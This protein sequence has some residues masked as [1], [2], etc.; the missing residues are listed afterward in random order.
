MPGWVWGRWF[1]SW[2]VPFCLCPFGPPTRTE[3]PLFGP[4]TPVVWLWLGLAHL[5]L[6]LFL[7]S[8]GLLLL[9]AWAAPCPFTYSLL[10]GGNFSSGSRGD[11]QPPWALEV[12]D[13]APMGP[14][15]VVPGGCRSWGHCL[16]RQRPPFPPPRTWPVL[17][18]GLSSCLFCLLL[19]RLWHVEVR[20]L[21]IAGAEPRARSGTSWGD[22][23]PALPEKQAPSVGAAGQWRHPEE[24]LDFS[25][26]CPSR[27]VLRACTC[28][29]QVFKQIRAPGRQAWGSEGL[30]G[31][32]CP[33]PVPA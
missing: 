28:L 14:C 31:K 10:R 19:L 22:S 26:P 16:A 13:T 27:D 30:V 12:L 4:H 6:F 8:P 5:F 20:E 18:L 32:R 9:A 3:L 1:P 23:R 25:P 15:A 17:G 2:G 21:R 11:P 33:T 29:G 7:P 24:T